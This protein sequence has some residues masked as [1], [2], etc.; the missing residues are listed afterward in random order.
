MMTNELCSEFLTRERRDH[1][2]ISTTKDNFQKY[3]MIEGSSEEYVK[4][5]KQENEEKGVVLRDNKGF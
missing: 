5:K 2:V 1:P 4:D 3:I